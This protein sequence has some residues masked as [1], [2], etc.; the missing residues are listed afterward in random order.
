MRFEYLDSQIIYSCIEIEYINTGID[1]PAGAKQHLRIRKQGAN[2]KNF[3]DHD[4]VP[5]PT[6]S[7][8]K[9]TPSTFLSRISEDSWKQ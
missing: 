8:T 4:S 9:N 6:N 2:K 1:I 3:T 7:Q 5:T